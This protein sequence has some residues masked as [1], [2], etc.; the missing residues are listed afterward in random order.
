MTVKRVKGSDCLFFVALSRW[1]VS[2]RYK[3]GCNAH[4]E[5]RGTSEPLVLIDAPIAADAV[6]SVA[7]A[8]RVLAISND[9]YNASKAANALLKKLRKVS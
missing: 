7:K 1:D 5:L 4:I 9:I 6:L 2:N 3:K 8:A